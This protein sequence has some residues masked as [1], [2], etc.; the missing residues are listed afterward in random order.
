MS[1][2]FKSIKPKKRNYRKKTLEEEQEA[3]SS[4]KNGESGTNEE[5]DVSETLEELIELRKFRAR[6]LGIDA[7]KL[8]RGDEK[9]KSNAKAKAS[10]EDHSKEEGG[11]K[12]LKLDS[13][14]HQTNTIDVNKHMMEYIEQELRKRRGDQISSTAEN[15]GDKNKPIDPMDLLYHTPEHLKVKSTAIR[16]GNAAISSG[17]LMAVP[18]V[19]LGIDVRL[20]NIE[21]TERAKR[22]LLES[23][24]SGTPDDTD[25]RLL[26]SGEFSDPNRFYHANKKSRDNGDDDANKGEDGA[27]A[28]ASRMRKQMATDD[29]VMQSY[30]KR[31]RR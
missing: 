3:T 8:E 20:K 23:D 26:A 9:K 17:M 24:D 28:G 18:E 2:T 16:E 30:K 1:S 13:F 19:D 25:E 21:A 10:G 27:G 29:I 6:P 12:S 7:R 14:T 15:G 22:Q 11:E 31:M 5:E 4:E